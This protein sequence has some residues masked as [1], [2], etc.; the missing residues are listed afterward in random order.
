MCSPTGRYCQ[1]CGTGDLAQDTEAVRAA[2]GFAKVDYHGGSYGGTD[3]TAYATRFGG[4]S[5]LDRA[6]RPVWNAG[7]GPV[8]LCALSNSGHATGGA[9]GLPAIPDLLLRSPR[10]GH[11]T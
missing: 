10:P 9:P 4:A 11:R 7:P 3:V 8:R 6:R 2:L 5:A 1:P